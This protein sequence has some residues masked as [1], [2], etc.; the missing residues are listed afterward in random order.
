MPDPVVV[1]A[2]GSFRT[3]VTAGKHQF[4]LDEPESAGGTDEGPT[5]YDA[6]AAALGGCTAMTL[7]F[8]ARREK[9]PLEGVD[10]EVRHDREHVKDCADCL[11]RS[12][13]IHRF[14]VKITLMGD[15]SDE[16]RERL[17]MIAKRC[18][19]AR[20]LGSE[21]RIDEVLA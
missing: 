9:L 10:V 12:G 4:V 7:H 5:P 2:R 8:Y 15:L 13:F 19:V 16:Q 6:L 14:S 1:S 21:I 3:E 20:T 18:P 11:T 17:L